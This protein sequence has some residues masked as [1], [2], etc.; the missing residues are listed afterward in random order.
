M[1][2]RRLVGADGE[3]TEPCFRKFHFRVVTVMFAVCTRN[4][5]C[6]L[7]QERAAGPAAG[8]AG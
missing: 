1:R 8:G 4:G 2:A 7:Y 5:L 3:G 6:L